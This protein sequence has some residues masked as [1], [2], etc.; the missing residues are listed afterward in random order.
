VNPVAAKSYRQR[1]ASSGLKTD[2]LDVSGLLG[3]HHRVERP[4]GTV[5]SS[6]AT[7][8]AAPAKRP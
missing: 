2:H 1:K 4:I 3:L 5:R 6:A 7:S 8:L